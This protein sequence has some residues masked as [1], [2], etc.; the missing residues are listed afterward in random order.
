MR[1]RKWV[2]G[3]LLL[4]GCVGLTA[5]GKTER[6]SPS[7]TTAAG[8]SQP[9]PAEAPGT[10]GKTTTTTP[11]AGAGEWKIETSDGQTELRAEA[12][13]EGGYRLYDGT[14]KVIGE[15]KVETDRVKV[16]DAGDQIV[17][18]IKQKEDGCKL[19]DANDREVAQVKRKE[20]G[21]RIKDPREQELGAIKPKDAGSFKVY[22]AQ[23]QE[24]GKVKPKSGFVELEDADGQRIARFSGQ[25]T[26]QA[27]SF[28]GLE[29]LDPL[30]RAGLIVYAMK[31]E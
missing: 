5:C 28:W 25:I 14:D 23:E 16:K 30:Q 26:P 17:W 8:P 29:N 15:V 9:I 22:N 18:K 27:A 24:I 6:V 10:T 12:R 19:Y 13:P 31:F 20:G 11:T 7:E 2:W 4:A 1:Q 21:Y 3:L